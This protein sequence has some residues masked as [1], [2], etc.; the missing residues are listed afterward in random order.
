MKKAYTYDA[1]KSVIARLAPKTGARTWGTRHPAAANHLD[2]GQKK[3]M[4]RERIAMVGILRLGLA[5]S[6]ANEHASLRRTRY[7]DDKV[8]RGQGTE[9]WRATEPI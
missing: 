5:R 9:S 6:Q 7:G 4:L 2:A 8:Q 3:E 1:I